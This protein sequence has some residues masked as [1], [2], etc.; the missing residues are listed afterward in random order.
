MGLKAEEKPATGEKLGRCV[1][2]GFSDHLGRRLDGGTLRCALV[3][4]RRGTIAR[5]S[6]VRDRPLVVAGELKEIGRTDGEVEVV[7]G[8]VTAVE[9]A[10]LK[11]MFPADFTQKQG[12]DFEENGRKVIRLD[13][14]KFRDLVLEEK[15]RDAEP[16]PEA[17]R[18]L[19]GAV[20]EEKCSWPGWSPEAEAFLQRLETVRGWGDGEW[21]VWDVAAKRLVLEAQCGGCLTWRQ[22]NETTAV[23]ALRAW[24]GEESTAMLEKMAPER[25]F[26][27][28]G[29]S[30][31]VKYGKGREAVI[32]AKIQDLYGLKKLPVIGGG[33]VA[34]TVEI[35]GPNQRPLQVTQDL[36]SFWAKTYP[37]LKPELQRRYP[38]HEW[39]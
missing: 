11:E 8:L 13:Q 4:H 14:M 30:A 10:W 2:A 25:I 12:L 26:L 15:K 37:A 22:A 6:V 28:G 29:K 20:L 32:S 31:K 1:L 17:A 39:R 5:E 38:K 7:M 27:P 35:L 9:E 34:V 33:K 19:A 24:L 18:V 21:P 23:S 16:G 36:S 3:G